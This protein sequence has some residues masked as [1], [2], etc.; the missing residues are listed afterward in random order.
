MRKKN[1][2]KDNPKRTRHHL[3]KDV[4]QDA[5]KVYTLLLRLGG[6][7]IDREHQRTI[8]MKDGVIKVSAIE[9]H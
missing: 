3:K 6:V 5:D 7:I 8:T 4:L 2:Y 9:K 1:W